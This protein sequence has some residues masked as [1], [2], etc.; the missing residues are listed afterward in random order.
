MCSKCQAVD[1][2]IVDC[3]QYGNRTHIFW[4][5]P[6]E[7]CIISGSPDRLQIRFM[8]FHTISWIRRTVFAAQV[9]GTEVGASIDNGLYQKSLHVCGETLFPGFLKFHYFELKEHA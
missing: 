7:K 2:L 8:L 5:G 3:E 1:V 4:Q 9:F 6:V